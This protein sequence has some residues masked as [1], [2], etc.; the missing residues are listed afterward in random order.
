[1][2]LPAIAVRRVANNAA[3]YASKCAC[4][5]RP[6]GNSR[7]ADGGPSQFRRVESSQGRLASVEFQ[8]GFLGDLEVERDLAADHRIH[9][10]RRHWRWLDALH[11]Q[12]LLYVRKRQHLC[13]LGVETVD[14]RPWRL[15][16]DQHAVPVVEVGVL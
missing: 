13:G 9:L 7:A 2:V 16:G 12:L 1:M 10:V 11:L 3:T 4:A 8:T 15:R 6:V 5:R 14:N